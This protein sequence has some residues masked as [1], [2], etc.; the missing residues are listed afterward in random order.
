MRAMPCMESFPFI[1]LSVFISPSFNP[2]PTSLLSPSTTTSLPSCCIS[3]ASF[4]SLVIFLN[5]MILVWKYLHP[6]LPYKLLRSGPEGGENCPTHHW[7]I[8]SFYWRHLQEALSSWRATS[9]I[10]DSYHHAQSLFALL[11]S[12]RHYR[13]LQA[14]TTR[15]SQLSP[16]WTPTP[17]ITHSYIYAESLT[18]ILHPFNLWHIH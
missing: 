9:I 16:C 17:H 7:C 15:F 4:F 18:L 1:F 11:P 10:K 6:L 8:T 14:R 2:H 5:N 3:S 12:G 13:N